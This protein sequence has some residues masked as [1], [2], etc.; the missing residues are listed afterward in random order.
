MLKK[1]DSHIYQKNY[2]FIFSL[3]IQSQ[4]HPHRFVQIRDP[5]FLFLEIRACRNL[6]WTPLSFQKTLSRRYL[7]KYIIIIL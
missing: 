3:G 5:E 6:F 4:Q 1:S 2:H 7:N